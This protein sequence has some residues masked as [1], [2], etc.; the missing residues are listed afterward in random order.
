[1]KLMPHTGAENNKNQQHSLRKNTQNKTEEQREKKK[2]DHM[3]SCVLRNAAACNF[4][5]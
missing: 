5:R 4:S 3:E 2:I 1:M